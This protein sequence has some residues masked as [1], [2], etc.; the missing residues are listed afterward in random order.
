MFLHVR[1]NSIKIWLVE[2]LV[3]QLGPPLHVW[4]PL[5]LSLVGLRWGL[6]LTGQPLTSRQVSVGR[7]GQRSCHHTKGD[8]RGPVVD[9]GILMPFQKTFLLCNHTDKQAHSPNAQDLWIACTGI[10]MISSK[11][12]IMQVLIK[13]VTVWKTKMFLLHTVKL[14]WNIYP[15]LDQ[16]KFQAVVEPFGLQALVLVTVWM[17]FFPPNSQRFCKCS[18]SLNTLNYLF[19]VLIWSQVA[20]KTGA[21]KTV[22]TKSKLHKMSC[23]ELASFPRLGLW[24]H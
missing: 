17:F 4:L 20:K 1:W 13:P 11:I 22:C 21:E 23:H 3:G 18:W 9:R 7:M 14:S 8:S 24:I 12:S 6:P 19:I 16:S 15:I 5:T 2:V 10:T